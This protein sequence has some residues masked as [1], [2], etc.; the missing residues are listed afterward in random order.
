MWLRCDSVVIVGASSSR[1]L[2]FLL[3]AV[4]ARGGDVTKEDAVIAALDECEARFGRV[5]P[6]MLRYLDDLLQSTGVCDLFFGVVCTYT[7]CF[8]LPSCLR[9]ACALCTILVV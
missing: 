3:G 5:G 4:V 7:V 8:C 6:R 2:K 9:D 1:T